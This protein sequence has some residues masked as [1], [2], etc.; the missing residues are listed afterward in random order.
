MGAWSDIQ[1]ASDFSCRD[2]R[3]VN[4]PPLLR[5]NCLLKPPP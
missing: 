5:F 3:Q 1:I 2:L 4:L